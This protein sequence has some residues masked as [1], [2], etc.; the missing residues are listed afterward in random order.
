VYWEK[1]DRWDSSILHTGAYHTCL[2]YLHFAHDALR[3]YSTII[4][5]VGVAGCTSVA[6]SVIYE[7]P[8]SHLRSSVTKNRKMKRFTEEFEPIWM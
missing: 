3:H 7:N 1:T 5:S 6:A 8:L 4:G 2:L